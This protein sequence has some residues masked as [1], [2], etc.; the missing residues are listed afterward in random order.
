MVQY[1]DQHRTNMILWIVP[2]LYVVE[3]HNV[4]IFE[5]VLCACWFEIILKKEIVI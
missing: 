4:L 3:L 2:T 5:I 1:T